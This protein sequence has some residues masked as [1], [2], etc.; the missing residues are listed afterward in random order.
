MGS[1]EWRVEERF[2]V[3]REEGGSKAAE[4]GGGAYICD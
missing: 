1:G 3:D 2:V 4:D